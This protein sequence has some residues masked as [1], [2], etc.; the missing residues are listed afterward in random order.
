[1]ANVLI[2][3]HEEPEQTTA[4]HFA[5][6]YGCDEYD[7]YDF[8][9][10][11]KALGH[12]VWFANWMDLDGDQFRRMFHDNSK[13]FDIH[14]LE[15][16]DLIF[17]YKMPGFYDMQERF[18]TTLD[19]YAAACPLVVN[20]PATIRHNMDKRYLWDLASKGIAIPKTDLLDA[21]IAERLR[22]GEGPFV[23][24]PIHGECGRGVTMARTVE[25]LTAFA[26]QEQAFLAQ[27]F[28][29]EVREGERSLVFLDRQYEHAV[30]KRPSADQE[31][32]FRCNESLGGRVWPH[33]P[34]ETEMAFALAVIDAY[35]ALGHP[36]HFCRIDMVITERGPILI[37]AEVIS[38]SQ[39]A[40]YIGRGEV[41]GQ[42]VARYLA[43]LVENRSASSSSPSQITRKINMSRI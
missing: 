23:L 11:L 10:G 7:C 25:D 4:H 15:Q 29:P 43:S 5:V 21:S 35:Q 27:E 34:D 37:E 18:H 22:A 33:E 20:D 31:W 42:N 9:N 3:L 24:K 14:P 17:T 38:P 26:G 39:Y 40:N 8:S 41:F 12:E 2:T 19:T 36:T 30:L 16:M 28:L 32:E 6:K 13:R 1:M